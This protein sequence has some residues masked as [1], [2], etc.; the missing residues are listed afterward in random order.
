LLQ[1]IRS[2]GTGTERERMQDEKIRD[3]K[4]C[5]RWGSVWSTARDILK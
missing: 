4:E 3:R 2:G 5:N 1:E